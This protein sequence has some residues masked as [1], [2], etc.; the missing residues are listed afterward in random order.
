VRNRPG[1]VRTRLE[2]WP[3]LLFLILL[4]LTAIIGGWMQ[5]QYEESESGQLPPAAHPAPPSH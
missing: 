4:V 2:P 5:Q 1:K 3:L